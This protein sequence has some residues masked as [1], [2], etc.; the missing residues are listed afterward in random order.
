M[1]PELLSLK[2]MSLGLSDHAAPKLPLMTP[3][4]VALVATSVLRFTAYRVVPFRRYATPLLQ[5]RSFPI[6]GAPVI[7]SCVATLVA[8]LMENQM[9]EF[10]RTIRLPALS[11]SPATQPPA[12]IP[13]G[14]PRSVIDPSLAILRRSPDVPAPVLIA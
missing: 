2:N 7:V 5:T 11:K 9:V 3:D 13:A 10:S 8:T 12:G 4:T 1:R 6:S 14:T